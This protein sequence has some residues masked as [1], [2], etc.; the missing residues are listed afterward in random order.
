MNP[1]RVVKMVLRSLCALLDIICMDALHSATPIG[2]WEV[3]ILG[4]DHT[5][6]YHLYEEVLVVCHRGAMGRNVME[7]L[8]IRFLLMNWNNLHFTSLQDQDSGFNHFH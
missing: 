3:R 5:P 1:L 6:R 2:V 4:F 8:P 7:F